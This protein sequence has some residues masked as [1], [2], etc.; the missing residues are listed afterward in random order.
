MLIFGIILAVIGAALLVAFIC[1]R[2]NCHKKVDATITK[3]LED[4]VKIRGSSVKKYIP[5]FT[6]TVD[7][8]EYTQK[9]NTS[10]YKNGRFQV[11]YKTIV[12]VNPKNP[13]NVRY[14]SNTE[15]LVAGINFL[16]LGIICIILYF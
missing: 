13:T 12:Y 5:V 8:K 10:T 3:V 15:F 7:G 6:Y 16:L 11:G 1:N 9:T 14:E 2:L 4:E